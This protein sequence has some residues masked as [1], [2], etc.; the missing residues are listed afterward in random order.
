MEYLGVKMRPAP[1]RVELFKHLQRLCPTWEKLKLFATVYQFEVARQ[2]SDSSTLDR[3]L[4]ILLTGV[5]EAELF[6]S[7]RKAFPGDD[8]LRLSRGSTLG[9]ALSSAL[10]L[11]RTT[12][13]TAIRDA[14][15][16]PACTVFFIQGLEMQAGLG[17]FRQRIE[18]YLPIEV[19]RKH[20]CTPLVVKVPLSILGQRP[21]SG[22]EWGVRIK[23][24]LAKILGQSGTAPELLARATS[25]QPILLLLGQATFDDVTLQ[26]ADWAGLEQLLSD[27]LP[28]NLCGLRY[29]NALMTY[30]YKKRKP[31]RGNLIAAACKQG[32]A[33]NRLLFFEQLPDAHLPTWND[34]LKYLLDTHQHE[35]LPQERIDALEQSYEMVRKK[36]SYELLARFIEI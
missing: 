25:S 17:F 9:D 1:T 26:D 30:E 24:A 13:F 20:G 6:E 18:R 15:A 14:C 28:R 10:G 29:V 8:D 4:D 3:A 32:K 19:K 16:A 7:L 22:P 36:K 5:T 21:R 31:P 12:Q 27:W 33:Y 35:P 34:A 23:D 11:D 2:I